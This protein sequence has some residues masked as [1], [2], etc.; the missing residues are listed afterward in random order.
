MSIINSYFNF[1]VNCLV[2][3]CDVK[4][5][6]RFNAVIRTKFNADTE[7]SE[8][9]KHWIVMF[10][11]ASCTNWIYTCQH[12][13]KNKNKS[14][15]ECSIRKRNLHC[16]A[17]ITVLVKKTTKGTIQND[18]MLKDG[19]NGE[20]KVNFEHNHAVNVG[21]AYSYLRV[22]QSTKD[23]FYEYFNM[24]MTPACARTYHQLNLV[25]DEDLSKNFSSI[26]LLA[27]SHI[28]PRSRQIYTLHD[29]WRAYKNIVLIK[30]LIF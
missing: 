9:V 23:K 16:T 12:S 5:I 2:I 29:E 25:N 20:I 13:Q 11:E 27:N 17:N 3:N 1:D 14:T 4:S 22:S 24:G 18:R 8:Q 19:F 7:I 26:K 6:E 21:E 10:S 28:N 15:S 30:N